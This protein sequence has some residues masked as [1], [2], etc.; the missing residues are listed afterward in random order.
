MSF[1]LTIL[2]LIVAPLAAGMLAFMACRIARA[3]TIA[4]A[5]LQIV[6]AWQLSG[7][8][9]CEGPWRYTVGGWGAPLGID[10]YADGLSALMV[11]MTAIVSSGIALYATAYF[12][13]VQRDDQS[14]RRD[15]FWPL[16]L[17]LWAALNALFLSGDIFN[18]YVTLELL[19]LAAVALIGLAGTV[20]ALAAALRYLLLAVTASLFYLL[21]VALLYSV[22]GTVDWELLSLEFQADLPSQCAIVLITI[23]LLLKTALVPLHFWL[24]PAHASAPAPASALLSA[25]VLKAPF[26]IL[27]RLWFGVFPLADIQ[28]AG[29]LLGGLGGVA[30]V[31]GALQA[32]RQRRLKLLVAYST[33]SQIGYLFLVFALTAQRSAAWSAWSAAA[34]FA[35]AHACAKA[36]AFLAAG[37]LQYATGSDRIDQ[38]AGAAQ[39]QPVTIFAFALAGVGLIGLPPSGAFLAKWLL[40]NSAIQS[41]QWLIA[42]VV[43]VGSVLAAIYVF[44]VV[45]Q[46]F[47]A[48][49]PQ[50]IR[51]VPRLMQLVPLALAMLSLALGVIAL[52]PLK[53]LEVGAPFA[54]FSPASTP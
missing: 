5:L 45:A 14:A 11:A 21:G 1:E 44:R 48:A 13:P 47:V 28:M 46:T 43:L 33:V 38:L 19:T 20:E 12:G 30:I 32:L 26:F 4:V 9:A 29:N 54:P 36:A 23:G 41:G 2:G 8:V 40:L 17:F 53:L 34:Y 39:K 22:Y 37:S 51:P 24:P 15:L 25:L 7:L 18:L 49:T 16:N 6:C 3:L 10:L 31:W 27:L 52:Q 35:V 50:P 42:L